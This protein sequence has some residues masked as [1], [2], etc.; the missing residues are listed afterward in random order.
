M[1]FADLAA[2][3][4]TFVDANVLIYL[5][6]PD[7][8]FGIACQQLMRSIDNRQLQGYTS[9]HVLAEVAHQLMILEASTLPGWTLG[10]VKQRLQQQPAVVRQLTLFRRAIEAVLQSQLRVLTLAPASLVDA[11]VISQQH[12]LL[13][14]DALSLAVMQANGLTKVASADTDFDRVPGITRYAP[15]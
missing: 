9:T 7:P 4:S 5:A 13:T 6:G 2:G 3:D 10:K 11:A 1:I 12:G 14:N 8:V 15:A